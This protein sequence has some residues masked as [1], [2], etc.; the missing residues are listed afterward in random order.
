MDLLA[1]HV[2]QWQ[3]VL[4]TR[5]QWKSLTALYVK[6]GIPQWSDR[7]VDSYHRTT[8]SE[9]RV[10]H[11]VE[12]KWSDCSRLATPS[13]FNPELTYPVR[14]VISDIGILLMAFGRIAG[15]KPGGET[16]I[17]LSWKMP[18]QLSH[19]AS[20]RLSQKTG[21]LDSHL[22]ERAKSAPEGH[23]QWW[24]WKIKKSRILDVCHNCQ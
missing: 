7:E 14:N 4:T 6:S 24:T 13:L 10:S 9:M 19:E 3:S 22:A 21:P 17:D 2:W 11:L 16:I 23:I 5:D 20:I 18:P 12:V 15:T 1:H 8:Q